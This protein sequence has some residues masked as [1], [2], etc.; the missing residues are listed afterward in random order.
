[1]A[2][3]TDRTPQHL[4]REEDPFSVALPGQEIKVAKFGT[5]PLPAYRKYSTDEMRRRAAEFRT[6]VQRRRTVREF[7]SRPVP[8]E[9]IEDCLRAAGTARNGANLQPWH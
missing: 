1:M 7:S 9:V 2:V 6:E 4:T 3:N 8:R 5:T